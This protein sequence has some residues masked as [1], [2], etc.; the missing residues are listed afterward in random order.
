MPSALLLD[1]CDLAARW[2]R[3]TSFVEYLRLLKSH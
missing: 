2:P 1:G 3:Q